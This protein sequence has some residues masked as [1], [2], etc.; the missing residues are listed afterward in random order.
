MNRWR[1][2]WVVSHVCYWTITVVMSFVKIVALS[3]HRGGL[4]PKDSRN[5]RDKTCQRFI[6]ISLIDFCYNILRTFII[7][8]NTVVEIPH[9]SYQVL[10]V[11][12]LTR[13]QLFSETRYQ[14]NSHTKS[15]NIFVFS[16]NLTCAISFTGFLN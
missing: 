11:T 16:F 10:A 1:P 12:I 15:F 3:K 13:T 7:C 9:A 2:V 4:L 5:C 6:L 14:G 8:C